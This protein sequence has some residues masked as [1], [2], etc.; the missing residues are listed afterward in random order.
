LPRRP[1][2]PASSLLLAAPLRLLLPPRPRLLLPM[3]MLPLL[4]LMPLL[5]LLPLLLL[6]L[7]LLPP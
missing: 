4:P 7:L 5:P 3:P 2:P 6:L 1:Q